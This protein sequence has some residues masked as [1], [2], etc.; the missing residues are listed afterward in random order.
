[1]EYHDKANYYLQLEFYITGLRSRTLPHM[2][3]HIHTCKLFFKYFLKR[4]QTEIL[5]FVVVVVAVVF[6]AYQVLRI[7]V[8]LYTTGQAVIT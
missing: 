3:K 4:H 6:K 8:K 7:H 2:C 5:D 1:M